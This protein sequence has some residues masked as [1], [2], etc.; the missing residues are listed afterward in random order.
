M[1]CANIHKCKAPKQLIFVKGEY[2]IVECEK[3]ALRFTDP[4]LPYAE[5]IDKVYDDSYFFGGGEGYADYFA[6]K[7]ILINHGEFYADLISKYTLQGKMLS[8]GAAAGFLMQGFKN[9]GWS[10]TGIELN[11]TMVDY[12]KEKLNLDIIHGGF[13][14]HTFDEHYNLVTMIQV[15]GHFY[16]LPG[17]MKKVSEITDC[18]GFVLVESWDMGSLYARMLGKNWHEYS[19]PSVLNWFSK[20]SMKKYFEDFGFEHVKTGSPNKKISFNHAVTLIEHKY[21]TLKFG[22]KLV[23]F[24]VGGKDFN[25]P[26]PAL[27]VFW[28]LFRKVG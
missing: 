26:Y 8:I 10:V 20:A 11:K 28:S 25:L 9:R 17:T 18:G 13:E 27:D 1:N 2:Q 15:I 14:T 5:H 6:E 12:G 7:D 23:E 4:M 19:P 3:C 22:T 16:D 21:P 24:L